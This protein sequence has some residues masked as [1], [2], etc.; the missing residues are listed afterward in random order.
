[1]YWW[2]GVKWSYNYFKLRIHTCLLLC[3][4]T[5]DRKGTDSLPVQTLHDVSLDVAV[6]E[7]TLRLT[8]FFAKL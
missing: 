1:M 3:R 5:D 2:V 6:F 4:L 8:I 7:S